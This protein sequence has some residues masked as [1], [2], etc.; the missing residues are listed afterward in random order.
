[1]TGALYQIALSAGG[2]GDPKVLR[3]GRGKHH[4]LKWTN[5]RKFM[6]IN[7][8]ATGWTSG[9]GVYGCAEKRTFKKQNPCC[10]NLHVV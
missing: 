7:E 6:M 5:M 2:K 9:K 8:Q 3:A 1:M 10:I 4:V